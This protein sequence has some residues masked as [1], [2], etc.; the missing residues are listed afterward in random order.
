MSLST[1]KSRSWEQ[2]IKT[3]SKKVPLSVVLAG[4][5]LEGKD[6]G[7]IHQKGT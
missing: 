3:I 6:E 1:L 5:E 4:V 2:L 7:D